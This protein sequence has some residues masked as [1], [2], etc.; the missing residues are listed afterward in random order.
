MR[1]P[2]MKANELRIGNLVD[3]MGIEK[4]IAMIGVDSV[5]LFQK[6][7]DVIQSRLTEIK[8]IP[9]TEEWLLKLGAKKFDAGFVIDRFRLLYRSEYGYYY[10]INKYTNEYFS[11]VEFVHEWQ[12]LFFA[13]NN[14]EL[15]INEL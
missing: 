8:P 7:F 13:M 10:V 9:L 1:E 3:Y 6:N 11:K 15:T 4:P 14:Q 12:N 5:M 2:V